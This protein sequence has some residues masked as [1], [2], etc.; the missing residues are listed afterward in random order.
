MNPEYLLRKRRLEI[1]VAGSVD[2]GK[3]TFIGRLLYDTGNIKKDVLNQVARLSSVYS[4]T[5]LDLALLVDGLKK[6]V[7]QGITID[8]AF[9]YL[10]TDPLKITIIDTPGHPQYS[11]NMFSGV[12]LA[13]GAIII[14]DVSRKITTQ[15]IRHMLLTAM[16]G[17]SHLL[18]CI[19]K[20]DA[21]NYNAEVIFAFQ[22]Q[23]I[24]HWQTITSIL[25]KWGYTGYPRNIHAI[26]VSALHGDNI[27]KPSPHISVLSPATVMEWIMSISHEKKLPAIPVAIVDF[28]T[29]HKGRRY[30][31]TRVIS[32]EIKKGQTVRILPENINTCVAEIRD[33]EHLLERAP[34]GT[35]PSILIE[36]D[37]DVS[38]EHIITG[39]TSFIL[40]NRQPHCI[41]MWMSK[42]FVPQKRFILQTHHAQ[43]RCSLVPPF[44]IVNLE[45]LSTEQS[46]TLNVNDIALLSLLSGE[47]IIYA[48][49]H[50]MPPL[51]CFILI[52]EFHYETAA[53]GIFI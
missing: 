21:V 15:T 18:F 50:I 36:D 11:R 47:E 45:S 33:G 25:E 19:N 41:L 32:G 23:I 2:D 29:R 34:A 30:L 51:G 53:A 17:P 35:C 7:E 52:D 43:Y 49:Y 12:T 22:R 14:T 46:E 13:D 28:I 40:R 6:E 38:T 39:D 42:S 10:Y 16:A 27:V 44:T 48:P 8:V 5:D 37:V 20:I 3:S 4:G 24:E 26:P 31:G 9:R 1:A